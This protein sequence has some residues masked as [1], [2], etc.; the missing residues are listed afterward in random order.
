M[1]KAGVAWSSG[2]VLEV[3]ESPAAIEGWVGA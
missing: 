3:R 1:I 2:D